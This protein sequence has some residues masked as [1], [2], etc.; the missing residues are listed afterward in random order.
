MPAHLELTKYQLAELKFVVFVEAFKRSSI[1]RWIVENVRPHTAVNR[2][3]GAYAR[4]RAWVFT[5]H[6]VRLPPASAIRGEASAIFVPLLITLLLRVSIL[7]AAVGMLSLAGIGAAVLAVL[8][9]KEDCTLCCE[10]VGMV[11]GMVSNACG[12]RCCR[13]CMAR[14]LDTDED[15]LSRCRRAR[16]WTKRCFGACGAPLDQRLAIVATAQ[17]PLRT[18]LLQLHRREELIA[19]CEGGA[20]AR[21]RAWVDCP[22]MSCVGVG[23]RGQE[24]IMC[25]IC[26]RQWRDTEYGVLSRVWTLIKGALFPETLDGSN[27]RPCPHCGAAIVKNGGC[28]NMRCAMCDRTFRW[29]LYNNTTAG[30]VEVHAPPSLRPAGA[31]AGR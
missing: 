9:I 27:W 8:L 21:G 31:T 18:I 7:R 2:A 22:E 6:G 15:L 28:D 4:L 24:D 10:S 1:C 12:C 17:E 25:F 13:T 19:R 3:R 29:G 20:E 23:Y 14:Y 30:V 11:F 16:A 26:E 5:R